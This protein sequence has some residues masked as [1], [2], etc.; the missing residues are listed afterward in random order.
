M[1]ISFFSSVEFGLVINVLVA[2]AEMIGVALLCITL[3]KSLI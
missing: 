2:S 3:G 1:L